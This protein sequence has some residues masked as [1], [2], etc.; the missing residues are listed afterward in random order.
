MKISLKEKLEKKI[1]NEKKY[2]TNEYCTGFEPSVLEN[3][4]SD[5]T[6]LWTSDLSWKDAP[7][8]GQIS[9]AIYTK[10]CALGSQPEKR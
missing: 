6:H 9:S 2:S 4:W 8:K 1:E 3:G 10:F 7:L 5:F